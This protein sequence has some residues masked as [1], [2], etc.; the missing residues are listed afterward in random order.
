MQK[1]GTSKLSIKEKRLPYSSYIRPL[2]ST[3]H[4]K[5]LG[6][7]LISVF[8]KE[9]SMVV[10]DIIYSIALFENIIN[11]DNFLTRMLPNITINWSPALS[12]GIILVFILHLYS[13]VKY[14]T[15]VVFLCFLYFFVVEWLTLTWPVL[16]LYQLLWFISSL[17][18]DSLNL[19]SFFIIFL[20]Y[21]FSCWDWNILGEHMASYSAAG[22]LAPT[23][24]RSS[25]AM[26]LIA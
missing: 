15:S 5:I 24:T 19:V 22:D 6:K 10:S 7:W 4:L 17:V 20:Y 3:L 11:H 2:R 21:P 13:L 12:N 14:I 8:V 25:A 26:V 1:C 23:V 18:F 16:L 9:L